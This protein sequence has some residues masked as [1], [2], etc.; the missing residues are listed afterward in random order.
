ML[1]ASGAA[2]MLLAPPGL[3]KGPTEASID[4]PGLS[5]PIEIGDADEWDG[6]EL[7]P[8]SPLMRLA[9][10]LGFF[11]AAFGAANAT[12]QRMLPA[13]PK[14]MLG[15]RYV[16]TYVV[17]GPEGVADV[18]RQDVYPYA[19]SGV[20]SYMAPGQKFFGW[21]ETAGGWFVAPAGSESEL[22]AAGLPTRPPSGNDGAG[23]AFPWTAVGAL[24]ALG[25]ALAVVVGAAL[26]RR[27]P[28]PAL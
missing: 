16:V 9:E 5:S 10:S 1:L 12:P 4:G 3:A 28:H 6:R 21:R 27:R 26:L 25:A 8:G 18:L 7:A 20:V 22:V 23:D 19:A 24:A 15:P 14:G 2:L 13:R 11:P 17:P